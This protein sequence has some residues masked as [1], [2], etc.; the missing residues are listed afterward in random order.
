MITSAT[1]LPMKP[2]AKL[3]L[4]DCLSA[5]LGFETKP[6]N[7]LIY[8]WSWVLCETHLERS[9]PVCL[10]VGKLLPPATP[11]SCWMKGMPEPWKW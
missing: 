5:G 7:P 4:R 11:Q 9:C 3:P 8:F 6:S 10:A 2:K 1:M